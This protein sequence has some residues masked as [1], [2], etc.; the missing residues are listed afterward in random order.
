MNLE[1]SCYLAVGASI[2][3]T[4]NVASSVVN[5]STGVIKDIVYDEG[6][7][8]P[9]LPVIVWTEINTY[10]G[11]SYF[12]NDQTRKKWYPIR[13]ICHNWWTENKDKN[14]SRIASNTETTDCLLLLCAGEYSVVLRYWYRTVYVYTTIST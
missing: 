2:I 4:S 13:P 7:K 6:R 14:R 3:V 1:N 9:E 5:G 10:K 11:Q 12:P 8:P